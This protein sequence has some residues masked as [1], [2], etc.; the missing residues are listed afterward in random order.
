MFIKAGHL[1][2]FLQDELE[3]AKAPLE[4]VFEKKLVFCGFAVA[5]IGIVIVVAPGA[6]HITNGGSFNRSFVKTRAARNHCGESIGGFRN[7]K[8]LIAAPS[9]THRGDHFT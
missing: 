5:A 3:A 8:T 9:R 1:V 4:I 7:S 2:R 6:D